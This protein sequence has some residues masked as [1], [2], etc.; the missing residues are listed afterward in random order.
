MIVDTGETTCTCKAGSRAVAERAELAGF[1][2]GPERTQFG[3][4]RRAERNC[5]AASH[6]VLVDLCWGHKSRD[7][8]HAVFGREHTARILYVAGVHSKS[9]GIKNTLKNTETSSAVPLPSS[10]S[11]S[12]PSSCPS[13][14]RRRVPS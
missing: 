9:F 5:A 3:G 14:T 1:H 8:G 4:A 2:E 6:A 13:S 11:R 10:L 7:T 12:S